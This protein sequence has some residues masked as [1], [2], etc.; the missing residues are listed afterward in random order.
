MTN[1]VARLAGYSWPMICIVMSQNGGVWLANTK[2]TDV[3]LCL[4]LSCESHAIAPNWPK[5][6]KTG[7]TVVGSF[8]CFSCTWRQA[9]TGRVSEWGS[10]SL[11]GQ[12]DATGCYWLLW[13]QRNEADNSKHWNSSQRNHCEHFLIADGLVGTVVMRTLICLI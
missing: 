6:S 4:K 5:L 2:R 13:N 8:R 7:R 3:S 10:R 1:D 12:S 11:R 9:V